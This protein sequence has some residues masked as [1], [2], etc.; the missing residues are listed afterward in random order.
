MR[1]ALLSALALSALAAGP[2]LAQS[3]PPEKGPLAAFGWFAELAG[4]CWKG[5]HPDGKSSDRQCYEIR[6]GGLLRGTIEISRDGSRVFEGEG[7]FAVEA[8][9]PY[10]TFAQWGTAGAFGMGEM[11][12]EGERLVFR[13]REPDGSLMPARSVWRRTGPDSFRVVRERETPGKGWSPLLEVD[14]RRQR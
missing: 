5:D 13:N 9:R 12:I 3:K 4:S 1:I 2:A 7:I 14:Y 6:Y 8:G 10:V 11:R